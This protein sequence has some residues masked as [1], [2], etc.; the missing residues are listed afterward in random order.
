MKIKVKV[1]TKSSEN[2]V[3]YDKENDLY[4]VKVT[5]VP[6]KGKANEKVIKLLADFFDTN[7]SNVIIISGKSSNVKIFE[8]N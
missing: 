6:E 8:I 4:K 1:I 2:K 3:E 7:K 5:V